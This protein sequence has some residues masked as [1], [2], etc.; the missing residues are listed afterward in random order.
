MTFDWIKK[1]SDQYTSPDVQNEMLEVMS[2][3]RSSLI[4]KMHYFIQL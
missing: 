1:K 4:F 3:I 2:N